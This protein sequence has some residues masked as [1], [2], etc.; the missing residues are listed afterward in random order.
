MFYLEK[1]HGLLRLDRIAGGR[2]DNL[3]RLILLALLLFVV[4]SV[5]AQPVPDTKAQAEAKCETQRSSIIRGLGGGSSR[6]RNLITSAGPPETGSYICEFTNP[7]DSPVRWYNCGTGFGG[8]SG[9][10]YSD[11][12]DPCLD[13]AGGGYQ[14]WHSASAFPPS[15]VGCRD[16]Q[17]ASCAILFNVLSTPIRNANGSFNYRAGITFT[18]AACSGTEEDAEEVVDE[19]DLGDGWKCDPL[20]GLCTDPDGNGKLCTFNPDGSRSNC[21]DYKPGDGT[22][23]PPEPEPEPDDPRDERAAS[24]GASCAAAPACS[25]DPI[26]CAQLWQQFKTRC[27]LE[28]SEN[29]TGRSC[30]NGVATTL[31]CT[32]MDPARCLELQVATEAACALAKIA[33]NDSAGGGDEEDGG[34]DTSG[35]GNPN[36]FGD[37]GYSPSD[38]WRPGVGES[39]GPSAPDLFDDSG[40]LSG[41][42]C[43]TMPVVE[44]FGTTIDFNFSELCWF[45]GIGANLILLFAAF[46]SIRIVS[47]VI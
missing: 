46:A 34:V 4:S 11:I 42:S 29:A 10:P 21:V 2:V 14:E 37:S 44:V 43:P 36:D 22:E 18:G 20:S 13:A 38:A 12:P 30:S 33:A 9:H 26:D 27:A 31:N 39:G 6:C 47:Q 1:H 3:F 28:K 7:T 19:E 8:A 23:P 32:N 41:R 24:G 35:M 16:F 40:F 17:G 45:L 15:G 25:G 5:Q